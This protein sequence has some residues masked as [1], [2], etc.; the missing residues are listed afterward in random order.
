MCRAVSE[1][2]CRLPLCFANVRLLRIKFWKLSMRPESLETVHRDTAM[3][4]ASSIN[5]ERESAASTQNNP[6]ANLFANG[7]PG[8]GGPPGGNFPGAFNQAPTQPQPTQSTQ[9]TTPSDPSDVLRR[10]ALRRQQE[11]GSDSEPQPDRGQVPSDQIP[12]SPNGQRLPN[13]GS[14]PPSDQSPPRQQNEQPNGGDPIT[15]DQPPDGQLDQTG[16]IPPG[17]QPLPNQQPETPNP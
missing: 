6:F 13:P 14:E 3:R 8:G 12:P 10:M 7:F 1:S 15:P 11:T 16:S 9:P 5:S 2:G 4:S 17:G